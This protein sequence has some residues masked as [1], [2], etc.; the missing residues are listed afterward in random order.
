MKRAT[1]LLFLFALVC[2]GVGTSPDFSQDMFLFEHG[3]MRYP[4]Y[5]GHKYE[6]LFGCNDGKKIDL[7]E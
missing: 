3:F 2:G 4:H 7:F 6:V 5:M 1:L